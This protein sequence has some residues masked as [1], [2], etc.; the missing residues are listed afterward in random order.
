MNKHFERDIDQLTR[1]LAEQLE[2][3][4]HN[5][6]MTL[7]FTD[8]DADPISD[9]EVDAHEVLIEEEALKISALHQPVADDLR[10][11]TVVVKANRDLERIGDLLENIHKF[12]IDHDAIRADSGEEGLTL[13]PLFAKVETVVSDA[14]ACL[15]N[16]DADFALTIWAAAKEVDQQCE[17]VIE[18]LRAIAIDRNATRSLLD[19]LLAVRYV[20]RVASHAANI[21]K[22]V[23]YLVT[24]EIVRHRRKEIM[25]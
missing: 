10:Y 9:K 5:A 8:E 16:R 1:L 21:A 11:L 13:L 23:I 3:I 25:G 7:L 14:C 19:A 4:K 12:H 6:R 15:R 20:E 18:K 22:D 17:V 24:G 2:R